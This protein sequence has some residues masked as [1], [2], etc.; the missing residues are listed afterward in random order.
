LGIAAVGLAAI[1]ALFLPGQPK[2]LIAELVFMLAVFAIVLLSRQQR[3]HTKWTDYRFLAE[4]FRS[5]LFLAVADMEVAPLRPPRHLSL[6]YSPGDW[7]V[8]AF[9]T[10]WKRRP[11]S[12]VSDHFPLHDL[13]NFLL[14]A[15]VEDQIDFHKR[16]DRRHYRRYIRWFRTSNALFGLTILA[17]L[18]HVILN[19]GSHMYVNILPL[20]AI[21]LP[22]VATMFTAIRTHRDYLRN[23]LRSTEMAHHLEEIKEKMIAAQDY[24]SFL[25]VVKETEE[26]MLHENEDWRVVVRFHKPEPVSWSE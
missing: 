12:Q 1:Q 21:I 24:N 5:A 13:K 8:S 18:L 23:S 19:L 22:A 10:V 3:W 2:I 15:W 26:T 11:K 7:M 4:R 17:A 25:E 16:T 20:M 14:Q 9:F 6:A